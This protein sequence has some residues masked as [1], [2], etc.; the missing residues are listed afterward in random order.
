MYWIDQAWKTSKSLFLTFG[1]RRFLQR[2]QL[3]LCNIFCE[4]TSVDMSL[5][6]PT[7]SA[8]A[9]LSWNP[10]PAFSVSARRMTRARSCR[11][12]LPY[13]SFLRMARAPSYIPKYQ[14]NGAV[15]LATEGTCSGAR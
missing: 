6:L 13:L 5:S 12:T 10:F 2:H 8:L 9:Q 15:G 1:S 3:E 11:W 7:S 4:L 14:Q